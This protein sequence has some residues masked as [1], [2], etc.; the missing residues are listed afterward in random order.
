MRTGGKM[1]DMG[2]LQTAGVCGP[3]WVEHP[4]GRGAAGTGRLCSNALLRLPFMVDMQ[5]ESLPLSIA[6]PGLIM[7]CMGSPFQGSAISIRSCHLAAA[8]QSCSLKA[9]VYL[10]CPNQRSN[11]NHIR[12]RLAQAIKTTKQH[13]WNSC[14]HKGNQLEPCDKSGFGNS[15]LGALA[16]K[17]RAGLQMFPSSKCLP[18]EQVPYLAGGG[19]HISS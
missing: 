1:W 8:A 12:G 17:V 2:W 9:L 19:C 7:Q 11:W 6:L 15:S 5:G 16:A 13:I 4:G 14:I 18:I 10:W 3:G